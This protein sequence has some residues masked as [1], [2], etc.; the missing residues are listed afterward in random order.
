MAPKTLHT[1]RLRKSVGVFL[2]RRHMFNHVPFFSLEK[3]LNV[4]ISIM[5]LKHYLLVSIWPNKSYSASADELETH[6]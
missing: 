4:V 5:I 3:G 6:L 1:E 2:L